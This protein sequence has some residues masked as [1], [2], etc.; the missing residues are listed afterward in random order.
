MPYRLWLVPAL[1]LGLAL[2]S[3]SAGN[4]Q[5]NTQMQRAKLL[6]TQLDAARTTYETLWTDKEF[7][8]VETPYQWSRR[9]L[10]VER[11]IKDKK[12][13][14]ITAATAHLERMKQLKQLSVNLFQQKL[15]SR[16]QIIASDFYVAEAE[17]WLLQADQ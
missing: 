14:Q 16:E 3:I 15:L 11:V 4:Q 12:Q 7:R 13:D 9:W 2:G 8:N 17:L 6:Q 1:S 10:E 5:P